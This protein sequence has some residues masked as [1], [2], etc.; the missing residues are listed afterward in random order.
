[1]STDDQRL[2]AGRLPTDV[3]VE[4]STVWVV[5]GRDNR[6]VALD[7]ARRD[8]ERVAHATGSSPLRLAVGAGSVWTANAGD[9]SV[10]RLDPLLPGS[11]RRIA[12]GADAVD[13]AVSHEGVWVTNGLAGTVTRIDPVSNR[14]LGPAVRTGSFPAALA[15]GA[16]PC[17][18]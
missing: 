8:A 7:R 14:V 13:V 3:A 16:D 17:G 4:G 18:S 12:I 5:S 15:I 11:G 2:R 1:M 9:D 6:V 10:T